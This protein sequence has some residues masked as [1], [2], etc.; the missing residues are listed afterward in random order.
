VLEVEFVGAAQTVTG[1]KH[2]VRTHRATVLLDCGLFQ[3]RRRESIEQN[4]HLRLDP[5]DLDAVVLSHAHGRSFRRAA[6]AAERGFEGSIFSTPATRPVRG[7][8]MDAALIQS[9]GCRHVNSYRT[10]DGADMAWRIAVHRGRRSTRSRGFRVASYHRRRHCPGVTL[11]FRRG[12]RSGSASSRSTST[13]RE[14]RSG[15]CS[16]ATSGA[17]TCRFSETPKC[18]TARTA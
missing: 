13:T 10:R 7:D 12:S 16:R 17:R 6:V 5:A 8:V 4:R 18:R 15:S 9:A 2:I 14:R 11:R 3:G 1:S